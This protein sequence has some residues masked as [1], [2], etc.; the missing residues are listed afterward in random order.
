MKPKNFSKRLEFYIYAKKNFER[1]YYFS[2]NAGF[3]TGS[4]FKIENEY[5][6]IEI[7]EYC[8]NRKFQKGKINYIRYSEVENCDY[9]TEMYKC[10]Y[11]ILGGKK[12]NK[13]FD[14]Y[15]K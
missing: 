14:K 1:V 10:T 4:I 7:Q 2:S 12:M 11:R 6:Y 9:F 5:V 3:F 15:L 8:T 13:L